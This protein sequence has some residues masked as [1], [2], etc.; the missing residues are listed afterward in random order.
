MIKYTLHFKKVSWYEMKKQEEQKHFLSLMARI[1]DYMF[2]DISKLD[3]AR[4]YTPHS[5]SDIDS[6]T[7]HFSKEEILSSIKRANL[8]SEK[9]LNGKLVIADNQKHNPID[10]I[11]KDLYNNFRIDL[12]LSEVM[13]N[14]IKINNIINKFRSICNNKVIE[15]SFVLAIKNENLDLAIDILFNLPYLT[16]RKFIIYLI[17]ERNKELEMLNIQE[18]IRDKAA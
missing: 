18:R 2:I 5:L 9:Y 10:V 17:N 8:V 6:F 16:L 14:K 3:I 7:M 11:N 1:G 4:G 13:K 15:D 12:Y